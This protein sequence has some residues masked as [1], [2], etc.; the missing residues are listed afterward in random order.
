V[1]DILTLLRSNACRNTRANATDYE[2][3]IFFLGD[4]GDSFTNVAAVQ[5]MVSAE[6]SKYV[7]AGANKA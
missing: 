4:G 2:L 6:F 5:A 3:I 7:F 1:N